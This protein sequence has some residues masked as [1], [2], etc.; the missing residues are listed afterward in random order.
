MLG[1]TICGVVWYRTL[2]VNGVAIKLLSCKHLHSMYQQNL[3]TLGGGCE[4]AIISTKSNEI[5][6]AVL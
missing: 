1:A 4:S 5:F 6:I 3:I 2:R